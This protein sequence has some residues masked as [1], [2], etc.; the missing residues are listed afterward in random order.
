M[1]ASSRS[2]TRPSTAAWADTRST[3]P[4]SACRS[5]E[6]ASPMSGRPIGD[7]ALI[8]DCHSAALVSREGSIDWLCAGRFDGPAVFGRLLDEAA[9]H[10]R[11]GPVADAEVSRGYVDETMVLETVFHTT[12]GT[13]SL[14]DAMALGNR[15]RGHDIGAGSPGVVIRRV[16]CLE[17][18]VEVEFE[19]APRPEYGLI[20]PLLVPMGSLLT[21]RGGA[22]VLSLSCSARPSVDG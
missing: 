8:S 19:Y 6:E 16:R 15:E 22:D 20:Q 14:V 2:A 3:G 1:G 9:G 18:A 7:Y 11:I 17:G 4:S 12:T 21:A 13:L 10:W 5:G